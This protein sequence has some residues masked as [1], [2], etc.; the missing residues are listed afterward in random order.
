MSNQNNQTSFWPIIVLMFT[1]FLVISLGM[2][3]K[4]K[5]DVTKDV[6]WMVA[7]VNENKAKLEPD[8]DKDKITILFKKTKVSSKHW[9]EIHFKIHHSTIGRGTS[10]WSLREMFIK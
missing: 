7:K 4:A 5:H 9:I 1:I 10:V 6:V 8:T 2:Y 3:F